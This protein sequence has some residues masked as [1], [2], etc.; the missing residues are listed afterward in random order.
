MT[1]YATGW[2]HILVSN[3]T[4]NVIHSSDLGDPTSNSQTA[5]VATNKPI[6]DSAGCHSLGLGVLEADELG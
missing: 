6:I 2:T 5:N 1:S 3:G 4:A